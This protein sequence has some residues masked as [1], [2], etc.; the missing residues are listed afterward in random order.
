MAQSPSSRKPG[1]RIIRSYTV[2][3]GDTSTVA[4]NSA[5]K[6]IESDASFRQH[7]TANTSTPIAVTTYKANAMRGHGNN[8]D[9]KERSEWV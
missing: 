9:Q 7:R 1:A 8:K 6:R 3:C 2:K 4:N 5:E